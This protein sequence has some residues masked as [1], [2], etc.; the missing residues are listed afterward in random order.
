MTMRKMEQWSS[1]CISTSHRGD[2]RT[3]W[4]SQEQRKRR[5]QQA[6]K[7]KQATCSCIRRGWVGV[8]MDDG[9]AM[10]GEASRSAKVDRD[11][12][13]NTTDDKMTTRTQPASPPADSQQ[14]FAQA[15]TAHRGRVGLAEERRGQGRHGQEGEA[16]D[17]AAPRGLQSALSWSLWWWFMG[18]GWCR[19]DVDVG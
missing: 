4:Y 2:Q 9:R 16:V 10:P 3:R 5:Q 6:P 1:F 17:H 14:Q 13:I 7:A 19:V 11:R 18:L 12:S 15:T 8:W